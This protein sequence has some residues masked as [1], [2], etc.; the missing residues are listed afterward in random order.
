MKWFSFI[1]RHGLLVAVVVG[2][3]IGY[4]Y[5][6]Q[7]F[8]RFFP[9]D[10]VT[11]VTSSEASD[12][13]VS[14]AE[15]TVIPASG[16][17]QATQPSSEAK[18]ASMAS[19]LASKQTPEVQAIEKL[20]ANTE[21]ADDHPAE[22]SLQA[23]AKNTVLPAEAEKA[24][25]VGSGSSVADATSETGAKVVSDVEK[26]TA[27]KTK[28]PPGLL[29]D[30]INTMSGMMKDPA[31]SMSGMMKDPVQSS[32]QIVAGAEKPQDSASKPASPAQAT[33][34]QPVASPPMKS[35]MPMQ[36]PASMQYRQL[37]NSARQA[38]WQGQYKQ[39]ED[40]Y[41]QAIEAEPGNPDTYG[42]LGNVYYAQGLWDESGES[43]Y[44]SAIRLLD[45]N[46]PDKA[47]NLLSII[48]GLKHTRGA[49]LESRLQ[50]IQGKQAR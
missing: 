36:A 14:P 47:Y 41:K 25:G 23:M 27:D 48:Q 39:S 17:Q 35:R 22:G 28:A 37:I 6:Y 49:E 1:F 38:Y 16:D 24:A 15:T 2:I 32:R 8:P 34:N 26:S 30:P 18:P 29:A 10:A 42:E 11:T 44:Q 31:Q 46:R 20:P 33:I 12:S 50:A 45:Q 40:Y 43:L 13:S 3:A 9:Q 19:D 7:L 4:V 21:T 5:R